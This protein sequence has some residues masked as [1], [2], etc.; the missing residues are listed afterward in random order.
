[1][2]SAVSWESFVRELDARN[3]APTALVQ[4]KDRGTDSVELSPFELSQELMRSAHD[5]LRSTEDALADTTT[6]L[7]VA[8][9]SGVI[10]YEWASNSH[11]KNLMS[12]ADVEA[13]ADLTETHAGANGVGTA[14]ARRSR[15]LVKGS[16]H[17]NESWHPFA[18]GASPII[19]PVTKTMMGVVNITCLVA[20]Q[21][22]HLKITLNSM[23]AGIQHGLLA[24]SRTRHQRL[25]DAHL[26]VRQQSRGPVV[27]LDAF[28]M[29]VEDDLGALIDRQSI[30]ELIESVGPL[31]TELSLPSGQ[32]LQLIP[33]VRGRLSEGCSL[34]FEPGRRV[35]E[36][37]GAGGIRSIEAQKGCR[38]RLGPLE[39]AEFEVIL[40]AL[41]ATGGNKS[42]AAAKLQISRGTLYERLRR[43]G[44]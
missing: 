23:V 41:H 20:E 8:D 4:A 34:V 43:Y 9:A 6:W 15:T 40:A 7:A 44:L 29:I 37:V 38:E 21:N 12:R 14:L 11:V 22:Q 19:H 39:Q 32:R 25:L 27:T 33:V 13:G 26:R 24:R 17:Y 42:E 36:L 10:T 3:T 1:M 31:A 18:C 28:T 2:N 35:A 30:W 16:E 5:V